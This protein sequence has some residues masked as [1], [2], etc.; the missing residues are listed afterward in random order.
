MLTFLRGIAALVVVVHHF[1]YSISIA[2][3]FFQE[4]LK[5]FWFYNFHDVFGKSFTEHEALTS[6][7]VF[8]MIVLLAASLTY[9]F[10]EVPM[11]NYFKSIIFS[12][13]CI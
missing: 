3:C 13:K 1:F 5:I 6:L 8:L 7:G 4:L 12:K 11:R 2:H 9:R 10:V